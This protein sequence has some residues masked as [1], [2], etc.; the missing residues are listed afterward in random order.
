M[1][2]AGIKL[3]ARRRAPGGERRPSPSGHYLANVS[4]SL[5]PNAGRCVTTNTPAHSLASGR[6]ASWRGED[7]EDCSRRTIHSRAAEIFLRPQLTRT[8]K[9]E[10]GDGV[11]LQPIHAGLGGEG[12]SR[13]PNKLLRRARSSPAAA[14]PSPQPPPSPLPRPTI[15]PDASTILPPSLETINPQQPRPPHH[16]HHA[17]K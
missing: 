8:T 6:R 3:P 17:I 9:A 1:V 13:Y 5:A 4:I 14:P 16:I 11:G 7:R 10:S 12:E 2:L 15:S